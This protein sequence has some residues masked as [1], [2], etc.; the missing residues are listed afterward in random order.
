MHESIGEC[1]CERRHVPRNRILPRSCD[2]ALLL[3]LVLVNANVRAATITVD[4]TAGVGLI[5]GNCSIVEAIVSANFNTSID[6]CAQG[7][8]GAQDTIAFDGSLFTGSPPAATIE[9][10]Q[11]LSIGDGGV[12][13]EPPPGHE[14]TLQPAAGLTL[15]LVE[16]NAGDRVLRRVRLLGGRATTGGAV[17]IFNLTSASLILDQVFAQGNGFTGGSTR[18][19]VVGGK[20]GADF[21]LDVLDSTFMENNACDG[22]ANFTDGG[23]IGLRLQEPM[24]QLRLNVRDSAFLMNEA[25]G[26]GGAIA[27]QLG[28]DFAFA[29]VVIY[30]STFSDNMSNGGGS[31][32]S[33]ESDGRA[34]FVLHVFDSVFERNMNRLG[35]GGAINVERGP[36]RGRFIATIEDSRFVDNESV[37]GGAIGVSSQFIFPS[38]L[39]DELYIRRNSFIGNTTAQDGGAIRVFMGADLELV[40]NT[41]ALNQSASMRPPDAGAIALD[42]INQA[43]ESSR[44]SVFVTGNTFSRTAANHP[45]YISKAPTPRQR[46]PLLILMATWSLA[47][48]W[49]AIIATFPVTVANT[50]SAIKPTA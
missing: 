23:V 2:A 36:S 48:I 6:A 39:A 5:D 43:A 16:L 3:L 35:G 26:R 31:A 8:A 10:E 13:I 9:L 41:F 20:P 30:S 19:G 40:N 32:I 14:L 46:A 42:Y 33:F 18:G 27:L 28:T 11:P 34:E 47:S 12:V 4:T 38:V 21:D 15:R 45:R 37:K 25:P 7:N 44:N 29:D 49:P 17:G 1:L 22:C 24:L 50:T